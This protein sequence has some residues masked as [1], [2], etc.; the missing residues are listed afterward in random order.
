MIDRE[1]QM[2]CW[3][4]RQA[5]GTLIEELPTLPGSGPVADAVVIGH[6][7]W[8]IAHPSKVSNTK[9]AVCRNL[10]A[11]KI[12]AGGGRLDASGGTARRKNKKPARCA[13]FLQF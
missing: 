4:W 13:G 2:I 12:D 11:G 1:R 5:G 8:R 7:K 3:S 6:G 10:H 9:V